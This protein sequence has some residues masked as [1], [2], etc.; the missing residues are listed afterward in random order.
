V[1]VPMSTEGPEGAAAGDD[2]VRMRIAVAAASLDGELG[3]WRAVIKDGFV[4]RVT[5]IE[6]LESRECTPQ[7]R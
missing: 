6:L 2:R 4:G 5:Y 3:F 1:T 7:S